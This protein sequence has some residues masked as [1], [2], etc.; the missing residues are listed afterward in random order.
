MKTY[1]LIPEEA[2]EEAAELMEKDPE[3]ADQDNSFRKML[4]TAQEYR[5][6]NLTPIIVYDF[7]RGNLYCIVKELQGVTIH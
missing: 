2:L 3:F 4:K 7:E 6:A 5:A 1:T